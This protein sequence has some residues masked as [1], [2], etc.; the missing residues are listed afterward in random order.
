MITRRKFL[1]SAG[2]L[3]G[4]ATVLQKLAWA[5]EIKTREPN[6]PGETTAAANKNKPLIE[7][8]DPKPT[9]PPGEPGKDYTPVIT[10]NNT[11]LP[12]KIIGGVKVYHLVAEEVNHEFAPGMKVKLWGFNGR[13]HGPTI[14]AVEG[15][16][17]RIYVTN[18][19]PEATSVHWHGILL[20]NGMDGVAG[21]NQKAIQPG[22]TFRYE[23]TLRQHGTHM[24]HSHSDEMTQMALGAMGLF[25]IHPRRPRDQRPDRDF[26]FMLGEWRL[27]TGT[28][29]PNPNE[30][31]DFNVFTF[32]AKIF[33]ATE[34]MVA[35]LGERVRIRLASVAAMSHHPIHLH[36][37]SF[38]ITET[39]G[40]QIPESAQQ[41][42]TTVLVA[43]GQSR[44][45]DFVADQPGDW[46]MHCHMT[47]HVMTQMGDKFPN[48][49][50]VH[51]GKLDQK[52]RA[53]LLPGYMTMGTNGMGEMAE[54][55]MKVP[56]NSLPMV[57]A[58]GPFDVIDMSGLLTLLKVREG[59]ISYDDPGWYQHPEGTVA[60]VASVDQLSR[61]GIDADLSPTKQKA[62]K[63]QHSG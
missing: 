28:Y 14:E 10:P 52:I 57:G 63:H 37:H 25:I 46:A 35:K 36:G 30:M 19:L 7:R 3:A 42:E 26:A 60:T 41:V 40:G 5:Q 44:T 6:K 32:N 33:P 38:R 29:R 54:M 48:T 27:D 45:F 59:I 43:I 16:R 24:Y 51:P 21:L 13:V 62:E 17:V 50:G 49:I 8:V 31:T 4:S 53:S 2:A 20:P 15:D 11:A 58:S 18:N 9:L 55:H 39:D 22:E 23:F 12:W 56:R 1:T 34:P 61:D 47:H